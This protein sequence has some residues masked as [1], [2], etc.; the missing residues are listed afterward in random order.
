MNI[1]D[2]KTNKNFSKMNYN[3]IRMSFSRD[4][5]FY[6]IVI[7]MITN[8]K[9]SKIILVSMNMKKIISNQIQFFLDVLPRI[10]LF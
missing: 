5:K 8:I 9:N 3:I 2:P 4:L 6:N 1:K 10:K 7:R